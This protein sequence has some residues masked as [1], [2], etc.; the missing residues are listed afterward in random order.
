VAV[1]HERAVTHFFLKLSEKTMKIRLAAAAAILVIAATSCAQSSRPPEV[2]FAVT[3]AADYSGL[4]TGTNNFWMQGGSAEFSG[5]MQGG[6]GVTAKVTGLHS[7]NTGGSIPLSIVTAT[8][9]PRYTWVRG[10]EK[11]SYA[12]FAQGLVGE[13]NGFDSF[14]PEPGAAV[15]STN[16]LAVQAGGGIDLRLRRRVAVRVIE[17]NWLRTQLP[18]ATTNVQNNLVLGAGI[19]FRFGA[20]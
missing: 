11:R 3:D 17:A 12:F 2:D 4:T 10:A 13:A 9:G 20:K 8:F 6:F 1:Q 19:V 7:S 16:S 15:T 5:T 14:F 18:N